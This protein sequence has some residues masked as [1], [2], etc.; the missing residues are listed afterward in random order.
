MSVR[1]PLLVITATLL[2]AMFPAQAR[3]GDSR[4][5]L[6]SRLR[7]EGNAIPVTD[8]RVFNQ[9]MRHASFRQHL[10][11]DEEKI[12]VAIYY[13]K[14]NDDR[15]FGSELVN[16]NDR[17]IENPDGW[18]L[19]VVYYEGRSMI[20]LYRRSGRIS[21][22]ETNGILLLNRSSASWVRSALPEAQ[23]PHDD[24]EPLL[25]HNLHRT[26]YKVLANSAGNSLLIFSVGFDDFLGKL[27]RE[28]EQS[29]APESLAGF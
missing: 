16:E 14:T 22:P 3:I 29:A 5:G 24:Y 17:P 1:L 19:Y 11:D 12:E 23:Y 15:A 26:D 6:E 18:L 13:K 8:E 21:D 25:G 27:K 4:S 9:L 28:R 2:L 20:E 7:G 10:P